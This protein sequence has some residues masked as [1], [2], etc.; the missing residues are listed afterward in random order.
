MKL[1]IE[2]PSEFTEEVVSTIRSVEPVVRVEDGAEF[3]VRAWFNISGPLE[4]P[5]IL[6]VHSKFQMRVLMHVL[7]QRAEPPGPRIAVVEAHRD[8]ANSI[9]VVLPDSGLQLIA[10]G[11]A[12][13]ILDTI[14]DEEK[15]R[16][17]TTAPQEAKEVKAATPGPN[18][19][20][21]IRRLFGAA[22]LVSAAFLAQGC[23]RV[24][25]VPAPVRPDFQRTVLVRCMGGDAL[26]DTYLSGFPMMPTSERIEFLTAVALA[27]CPPEVEAWKKRRESQKEQK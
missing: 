11:V 8:E 5:L 26:V 21:W 15:K 6:G 19:P 17:S 7:D 1:K 12:R 14:F 20:S 25:Q 2:G 23:V 16:D 4:H 3:T 27:S 18:R 22:G 13:A 10:R 24:I 9:S